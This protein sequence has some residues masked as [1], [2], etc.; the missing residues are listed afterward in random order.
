MNFSELL[1]YKTV[2]IKIFNEY[3]VETPRI[4]GSTIHGSAREDSDVDFLISWPVQHSLIDR[5]R[6]KNELELVLNTKVD[7]VTDQTIHPMIRD[8]VLREAR[9]L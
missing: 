7:L 5:I 1:R 4:F 2:L 8:N 3:G 9:P 6:L